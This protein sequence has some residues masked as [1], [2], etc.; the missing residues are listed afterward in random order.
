MKLH[1]PHVSPLLKLFYLDSHLLQLTPAKIPLLFSRR[2]EMKLK[3]G[4]LVEGQNRRPGKQETWR[5]LPISFLTS[6]SLES[7]VCIM[8]MEE[9]IL[10]PKSLLALF[11]I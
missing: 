11:P 1:T 8:G 6:R 4:V 9:L 3:A 5:L 10:I 2:N 7:L